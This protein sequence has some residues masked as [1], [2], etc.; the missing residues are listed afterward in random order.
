MCVCG[1][2]R[3]RERECKKVNSII[4]LLSHQSAAEIDPGLSLFTLWFVLGPVN[5]LAVRATVRRKLA[6]RT[7]KSGIFDPTC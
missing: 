1:R 3:E 6:T 4:M 7:T 5:L 2:E